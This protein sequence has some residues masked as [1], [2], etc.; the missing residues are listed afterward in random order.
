MSTYLYNWTLR[1]I[2]RF[3][4]KFMDPRVLTGN[5]LTVEQISALVQCDDVEVL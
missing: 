3:K 1:T 2:T 5:H 4:E